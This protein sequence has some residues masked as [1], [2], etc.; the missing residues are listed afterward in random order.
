MKFKGIEV[1]FDHTPP[2]CE[3]CE[4]AR[5][6]GWHY[7]EIDRII[8]HNNNHVWPGYAGEPDGGNYGGSDF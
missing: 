1:P 2:K 3:K 7:D 6:N 5:S 4:K 8:W